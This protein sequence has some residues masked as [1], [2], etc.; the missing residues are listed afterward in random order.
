MGLKLRRSC[1]WSLNGGSP[2]NELFRF[3]RFT[4]IG[5]EDWG[6]REQGLGELFDCVVR[7]N[8]GVE[9]GS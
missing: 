8:G 2:R 7:P 3:S 9:Y 4:T 6:G 1:V 5:T